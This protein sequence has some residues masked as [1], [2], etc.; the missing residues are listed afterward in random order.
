MKEKEEFEYEKQ[1]A[2]IVNNCKEKGYVIPSYCFK[3]YDDKLKYAAYMYFNDKKEY[4]SSKTWPIKRFWYRDLI[5][6]YYY[7]LQI[8][9]CNNELEKYLDFPYD[10]NNW[11]RK[12]LENLIVKYGNNV[13]FHFAIYSGLK[14]DK[15]F[16]EWYQ[17]DYQE[18]YDYFDSIQEKINSFNMFDKVIKK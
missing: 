16:D 6:T 14:T 3:T 5:W 1:F 15:S 17:S 7:Y 8:S 12:D 9:D 11:T 4:I 18:Y 2:I 13:L 10:T